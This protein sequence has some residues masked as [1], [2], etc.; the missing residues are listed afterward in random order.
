VPWRSS[1]APWHK[2][3]PRFSKPK[4]LSLYLHV[5]FLPPF[6]CVPICFCLVVWY[7]VCSYYPASLLWSPGPRPS[8]VFRSAV[9]DCL[10]LNV[11]VSLYEVIKYTLSA[12]LLWCPGPR[13]SP[14]FRAAICDCLSLKTYLSLSLSP[15]YLAVPEA[16]EIKIVQLPA[17]ARRCTDV[18]ASRTV[19]AVTDKHEGRVCI[20]HFEDIEYQGGP[21]WG[22]ESSTEEPV[23]WISRLKDVCLA[24]LYLTCG[25]NS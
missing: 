19:L 10:S 11:S 21:H 7:P 24:D 2:Q 22:V 17:V 23:R 12:S 6:F 5:V 8:P 1:G 9:C 4:C 3:A 20:S 14:V 16:A 25:G 13:P 15:K 18:C